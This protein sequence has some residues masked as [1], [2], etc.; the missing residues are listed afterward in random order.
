MGQVGKALALTASKFNFRPSEAADIYHP[1]KAI[2]F[3]MIAA[4]VVAEV[5]TDAYSSSKG[6]SSLSLAS[7]RKADKRF[8]EQEKIAKPMR[9]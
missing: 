4:T 6:G 1:T 7:S 3:D 8:A 9:R 5:E 2:F